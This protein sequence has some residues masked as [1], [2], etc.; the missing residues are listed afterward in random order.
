MN[1]QAALDTLAAEAARGDMVFPTHADIALRV[2]RALDDPDCSIEQLSKLISAEPI[3]SAKVVSVA[4]SVAYNASGRAMSDV[5][6]AV[7]RLGF[8]T[9][10]TMTTAVVVRQM[11]GMAQSPAHRALASRM[12]PS[13]LATFL[14]G[15]PDARI[16]VYSESQ[17]LTMK[18]LAEG[19]VDAAI[20]FASPKTNDYAGVMIG[21]EPLQ[22]IAAPT[23]PL[24]KQKSV[25][26]A[27][28]EHFDFV[29]GLQE[30]EGWAFV[31]STVEDSGFMKRRVI[32][33]MQGADSVNNAVI[34]GI[35]LACTLASAA[36]QGIAEGKLVALKTEPALRPV[37][38]KW[39]IREDTMCREVLEAFIPALVAAQS[40]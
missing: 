30:S 5:R 7:S 39:M 40:A 8:N 31:D 20:A 4:N 9:L 10:R 19:R 3:L 17:S 14:R 1:I 28:L 29:A 33:R 25:A 21:S 32:L 34:H 18:L 36:R 35:G 23:H 22:I 26:L 37:P 11:E 38:I 12:M 24:A 16:S 27:D 15:R 2:Q 13:A 6:S